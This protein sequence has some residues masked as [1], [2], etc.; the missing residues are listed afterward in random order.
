MCFEM[1]KREQNISEFVDK[2]LQKRKSQI[3]YINFYLKKLG[4]EET[5]K[6]KVAEEQK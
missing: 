1:Y 2:A 6:P 3:S 5:I 4:K